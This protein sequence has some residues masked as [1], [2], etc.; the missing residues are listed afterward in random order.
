MKIQLRVIDWN[1]LRKQQR[2]W[3]LANHIEFLRRW[4][5]ATREIVL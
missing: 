2:R 4:V 5:A 3:Q 1:Q